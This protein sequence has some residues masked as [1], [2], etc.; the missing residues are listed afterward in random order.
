MMVN[1]RKNKTR[2]N[3]KILE[4]ANEERI[5]AR[6]RYCSTNVCG[7]KE[8]NINNSSSSE[9]DSDHHDSDDQRDHRS[10]TSSRKPKN[11][12]LR[13]ENYKRTSTHSSL[14]SSSASGGV[15]YPNFQRELDDS[16]NKVYLYYIVLLIFITQLF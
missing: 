15:A 8:E 2:K 3:N 1:E 10:K 6:Q 13:S 12:D 14:T 4:K 11:D 9:G 7:E 5:I 16:S